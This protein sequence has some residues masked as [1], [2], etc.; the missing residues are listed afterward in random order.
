MPTFKH[1]NDS[2]GQ[3]LW[4]GFASPALGSAC[5]HAAATAIGHQT[6][7]KHCTDAAPTAC[8]TCL[9]VTF[10]P[11][12]YRFHR[13]IC[14]HC[15]CCW[16][17]QPVAAHAR[18]L[19]GCWHSRTHPQALLVYGAR[20]LRWPWPFQHTASTEG[21]LP[22]LFKGGPLLHATIVDAS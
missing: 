4:P 18:L 19:A 20:W 3:G 11:P 16:W 15:G 2:A 6:G 9:S 1:G 22:Q 10:S 7:G 14:M 8:I 12:H 21:Q 13:I 17:Q 5:A